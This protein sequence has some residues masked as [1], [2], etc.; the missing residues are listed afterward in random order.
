VRVTRAHA[1][2]GARAR[3]NSSMATLWPRSASCCSSDQTSKHTKKILYNNVI[4]ATSTLCMKLT[5]EHAK[6]YTLV[7]A[8]ARTYGLVGV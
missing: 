7:I 3:S 4:T 8:F 6:D 2:C 5:A 1:R